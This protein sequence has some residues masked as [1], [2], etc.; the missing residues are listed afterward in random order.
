MQIT[1]HNDWNIHQNCILYICTIFSFNL[2]MRI[3]KGDHF[4]YQWF[5]LNWNN[6]FTFVVWS[7]STM[8]RSVFRCTELYIIFRFFPVQKSVKWN[9][10]FSNTLGLKPKLHGLTWKG[11][12]HFFVFVWIEINKFILKLCWHYI[13]FK[14]I[15]NYITV[16][17][18]SSVTA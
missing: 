18:Q 12:V 11:M 4:R 17:K 14:T 16:G 9:I 15:F 3:R 13:I 2:G 6:C 7:A 5:R 8:L 10:K 1:L